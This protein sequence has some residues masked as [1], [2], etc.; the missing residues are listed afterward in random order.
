[1]VDKTRDYLWLKEVIPLYMWKR[2]FW[3]RGKNGNRL[4]IC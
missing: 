4:E 3:M 2:Y 1:M